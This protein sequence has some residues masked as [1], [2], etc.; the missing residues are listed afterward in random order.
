MYQQ[1]QLAAQTLLS[2]PCFKSNICENNVSSKITFA[3]G[4]DDEPGCNVMSVSH[5]ILN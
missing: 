4:F 5:H 3:Q 1:D 2:H